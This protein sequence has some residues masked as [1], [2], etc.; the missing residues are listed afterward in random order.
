MYV[1]LITTPWYSNIFNIISVLS[2]LC[3]PKSMCPCCDPENKLVE[4]LYNENDICIGGGI[5]RKRNIP[6]LGEEINE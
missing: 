1:S 5:I 3:N 2:E 6:Y 4:L